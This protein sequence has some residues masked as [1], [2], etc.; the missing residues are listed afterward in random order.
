METEVYVDY[1]SWLGGAFRDL[2][3]ASAGGDRAVLVASDFA[4]ELLAASESKPTGFWIDM[5]ELCL[6]GQLA[7]RENANPMLVTESILLRL[8]S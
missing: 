3:A 5:V 4:D 1:L 8:A 6:E 2:A 7:I